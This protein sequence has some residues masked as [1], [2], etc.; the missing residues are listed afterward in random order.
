VLPVAPAHRR[1]ALLGVVV[2]GL[3]FGFLPLSMMVGVA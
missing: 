3:M 2:A 1:P